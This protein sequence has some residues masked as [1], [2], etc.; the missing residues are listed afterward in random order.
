MAYTYQ[1]LLEAYDKV[2]VKPG[3][4]LY[5]LSD[6][7]WLMEY[8]EPGDAA[9]KAHVKALRELIGPSGTIAMP[10]STINLCN[11]DI[12][13]DVDQT[14]SHRVG[15]LAEYFRTLPGTKRSFHPFVSIAANGPLAGD[16]V[17]NVARHAFGPE[18]PQDR[19]LKLGARTVSIGH[20]PRWTATT[21]HHVE[22]L[23]A[24]PYRYTKEFMHPVVRDGETHVEPF[25]RFVMYRDIGVE[26]DANEKLFALI[27]DELDVVE[28]DVGRGK[29]YAYEMNRFYDLATREFAKDIYVWCGKLPHTR[30]YRE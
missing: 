17:D 4:L 21:V 25:Y 27:N 16:I 30:P 14:P 20:T 3:M 23:M 8:E 26:R 28:A 29:V 19:M 1:D 13:F 22:H 5:V 18:T 9:V 2:G 15:V 10:A 6:L 12:P 11:T 24:V 7:R